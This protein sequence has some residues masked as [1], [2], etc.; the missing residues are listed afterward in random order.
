MY[1]KL[2]NGAR[3]KAK[4]CHGDVLSAHGRKNGLVTSVEWKHETR[5]DRYS[6]LRLHTHIAQVGCCDHISL[7]IQMY[8][9][10]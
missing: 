6:W 8:I 3:L 1:T 5:V 9:L 10:Y 4:G 2:R 7:Y